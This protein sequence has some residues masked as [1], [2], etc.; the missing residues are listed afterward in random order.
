MHMKKI[1]LLI[2]C[3]GQ[4]AEH[5]ISLVSTWNLLNLLDCRQFDCQLI[6][7]DKAGNWHYQNITDFLA[8]EPYP[9]TISIPNLDDPIYLVTGNQSKKFYQAKENSFLSKVD[10][11]FPL[12]HGPNG[13]DGTMQGVLEQLQIPYVGCGVLGSS[14]CMDK[15]AA[16][17]L[18]RDAGIPTSKWVAFSITEQEYISFQEVKDELGLPLFIKPSNMGSSVGISKVKTEDEFKKAVQEAFLYDSK[19]IIEEF[20]DGVE[21]ECAVLGNEDVIVSSPGMYVHQDDF[22]DFDTKYLKKHEVSMQIPAD[23]LTKKQCE[24]LKALSKQAYHTLYCQGLSRV[25]TFV[26]KEGHYFVNEI[27]TMPGFTQSSMYP[28]LLEQSGLSYNDLVKRLCILALE[29]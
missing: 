23:F 10:V 16:K 2:L 14:V 15:D 21:V 13:E 3:G 5:Q 12:L 27:N 25:D 18:M 9:E 6:A 7:I 1:S 17:R 11:V 19:I 22:F 29:Q 20:V 26:T 28:V 24:E 8:Q 4:S